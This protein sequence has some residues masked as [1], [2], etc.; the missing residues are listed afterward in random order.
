[1]LHLRNCRKTNSN[2]AR[3]FL[4]GPASPGARH[5]RPSIS[6][7]PKCLAPCRDS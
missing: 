7:G 3:A 5:F 6:S 4:R 2:L 1:V